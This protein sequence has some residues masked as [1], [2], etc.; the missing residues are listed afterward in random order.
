[1]K[2]FQKVSKTSVFKNYSI[3]CSCYCAKK[4]WPTLRYWPSNGPACAAELEPSSCYPEM[5]STHL[6]TPFWPRKY[7]VTDENN[8]LAYFYHEAFAIREPKDQS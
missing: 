5:V 8:R 2:K 1:M 7:V 3:Y 6:G 4:A